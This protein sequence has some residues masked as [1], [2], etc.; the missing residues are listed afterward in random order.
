MYRYCQQ[1]VDLG[2]PVLPYLAEEIDEAVEEG[3]LMADLLQT[4]MGTITKTK[5]QIVLVRETKPGEWVRSIKEFPEFEESGPCAGAKL[6][7]RWWE[8]GRKQT[9]ER[10]ENLCKEWKALRGEGKEEEA[11]EKYGRIRDL[12]IVALP[13][14]M[15]KVEAGER[16]LIPALSYLTDNAVKPYAEPDE[17]AAWWKQNRADW[18]IPAEATP[19]AE[20]K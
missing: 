16:S 1:I 15:E 6:W 9:P 12:G 5:I 13:C 11:W 17:C 18:T 8:E 20:G 2:L 3:N 14:I 7:L 10:F 19:E 4:A